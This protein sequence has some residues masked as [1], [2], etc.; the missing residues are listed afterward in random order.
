[1][2][3]LL[4][5]LEN[6]ILVPRRSK[7]ER[8]KN[9][10]IAVQKQIK[11]YIKDGRE[12]DLELNGAPI[13]SLPDN[14]RSV[15]GSLNLSDSLITSLPDDL[16][17]DGYLQLEDCKNLT[18]LPYGLFVES[19]LY[20]RNTPITSL[21]FD[22]NIGGNLDLSNTPIK[23]LPSSLGVIYSNLYLSFCKNL[24]SLPD[25]LSV[26]GDIHLEYSSISSLPPNLKVKGNV[27]LHDTPLEKTYSKEQIKQM[28]P[29]IKGSI[30]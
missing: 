22:L 3:K 6:N 25:G 16:K 21:P 18:S 15:G 5:I 10:F 19:G 17:I 13:T 12:G 23:S 24:T 14:L 1:M 9:Y 29:G 30:N 7:E 20:L 26:V 4:D 28:V 27:W 2:I 8:A 11:Q